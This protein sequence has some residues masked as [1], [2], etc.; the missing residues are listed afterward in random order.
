MINALNFKLSIQ[1][2]IKSR[3]WLSLAIVGSL[4]SFPAAAQSYS[5]SGVWVAMDNHFSRS[6]ATVCLTLKTF[7]I[8]VLVDESFPK[9]MIFADGKRYEARGDYQAEQTIRSVKRAADGGFRIT[10]SLGK[11]GRWPPW[12]KKQTYT[13]RIVDPMTIEITEG[14][15]STQFFKCSSN[16]PSL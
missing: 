14:K 3:L 1:S 15:V 6:K 4:F 10:E 11:H 2:G 7:G 8:D 9:L 12:S 5:V 16:S 13:L